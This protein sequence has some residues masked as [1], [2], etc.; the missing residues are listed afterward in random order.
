M[1]SFF[2]L[3]SLNVLITKHFSFDEKCKIVYTYVIRNTAGNLNT[4]FTTADWSTTHDVLFIVYISRAL[5]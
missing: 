2:N 5:K 3:L 4:Y 1:H